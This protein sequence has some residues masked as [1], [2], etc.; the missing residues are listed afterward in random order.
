MAHYFHNIV[1]MISEIQNFFLLECIGKK[2][3]VSITPFLAKCRIHFKLF[4]GST[5]HF[6]Q[7]LIP[8][9]HC[10]FIKSI[11]REHAHLHLCSGISSW[12]QLELF[13][14]RKQRVQIRLR[15]LI[16][17]GKRSVFC[18]S[19]FFGKFRIIHEFWICM[20]RVFCQRQQEVS[21]YYLSYLRNRFFFSCIACR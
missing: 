7:I 5:D 16:Q 17:N 18:E 3:P 6:F 9:S 2:F 11:G 10:K 21:Y 14:G 13:F 4:F 15:I 8:R 12:K 19:K 20:G 1:Y